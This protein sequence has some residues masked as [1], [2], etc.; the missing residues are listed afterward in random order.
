MQT[1][2]ISGILGPIEEF[3]PQ[4]LNEALADENIDHVDIFEGSKENIEK[5]TKLVGKKYTVSKRFQKTGSVHGYP[6]HPKKRKK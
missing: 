1:V 2:D 4:R 5:R 3:T 6:G